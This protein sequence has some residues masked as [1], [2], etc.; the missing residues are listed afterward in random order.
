MNIVEW[1]NEILFSF[2]WQLRSSAHCHAFTW[3]TVEDA[4]EHEC[5]PDDLR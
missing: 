5:K 1:D 2:Q 4:S 3:I